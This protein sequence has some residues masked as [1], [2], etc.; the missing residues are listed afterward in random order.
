MEPAS[1]KSRIKYRS[2]EMFKIPFLGHTA[3][4]IEI[5]D[6]VIRWVEIDRFGKNWSLNSFGEIS[7]NTSDVSLRNAFTHIKSELK[8]EACHIGFS[9]SETV[10]AVIVEEVPYS[11][12]PEEVG[13]WVRSKGE[14]ILKTW[15]TESMHIETQVVS[16]DEDSKRCIFQVL[17][18]SLIDKYRML[19][20][21][22][23][24]YSE[25]AVSGIFESGYAMIF[26]QEFIAG[27]AAVLVPGS[28]I[29]F[30][31]LFEHGTVRNIYEITA[32]GQP[33]NYN[34]LLNEANSYL[35]TEEASSDRVL[36]SIP[37]WLTS[38]ELSNGLTALNREI[39]TGAA[40]SGKKGFDNLSPEY[41]I[42]SGIVGKLFFKGLDSFNFISESA[43]VESLMEYDKQEF[44]RMSVLLFVPL[45]VF[46]LLSYGIDKIVDYKLVES[47]QI[48][49]QIGD[50]IEEVSTS[51]EQLFQTRDTFVE[52]R[53]MILEKETFAYLFELIEKKIPE[54]LWLQN[55]K[56]AKA[57]G[58]GKQVRISGYGSNSGVITTFLNQLERSELVDQASLIVSEKIDPEN[59]R[60]Q[61]INQELAGMVRFEIVIRPGE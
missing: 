31:V 10:K 19:L 50:K 48:M 55:L 34:Y 36:G 20:W 40:L 12:E 30:L 18:K 15:D 46:G 51:R 22:C 5:T 42:C 25:L 37:I 27:L 24:L 14:E 4:G 57:A 33:E 28:D 53:T 44:I 26:D 59:G 52:A 2:I 7:H 49:E 39:R 17:D 21:E 35:Q 54:E 45:I 43:A 56:A 58:G 16:L 29:S 8:A 41:F 1:G 13:H 6:D 60:R 3:V 32:G 9:F 61:G 11:E 47:N 23:G 38:F